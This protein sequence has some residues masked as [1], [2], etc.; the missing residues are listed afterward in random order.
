MLHSPALWKHKY[1]ET[2]R[3]P[4]LPGTGWVLLLFGLGFFFSDCH[5]CWKVLWET[6]GEVLSKKKSLF[7]PLPGE[8]K[9]KHEIKREGLLPVKN[10]AQLS[11]WS[12]AAQHQHPALDAPSCSALA[13]LQG[14]RQGSRFC[15]CI[16]KTGLSKCFL[17]LSQLFRFLRAA[18]AQQNPNPHWE[19]CAH[20]AQKKKKI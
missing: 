9:T 11:L 7:L 3:F 2:N 20:Q 19:L 6:S 16:W 17:C 4:V 14:C 18:L 1:K 12:S 13:F 15:F 10:K 5:I 8:K